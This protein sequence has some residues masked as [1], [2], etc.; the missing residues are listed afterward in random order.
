MRVVFNNRQLKELY[1]KGRSKKF[2]LPDEVH[3]KFFMRIQQLEA[4]VSIYDLQ[5]S[6]SLHFEKLQ[7]FVNRF[8]VRLNI[9]WRM[10]FEIDWEDAEKTKGVCKIV[11][12]NLHYRK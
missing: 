4:A 7:G 5:R 8:S 11:D 6:A 12:L 1:A 3:E 9:K 10:E 2:R